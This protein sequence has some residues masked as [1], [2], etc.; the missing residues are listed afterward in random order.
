MP[1]DCIGARI[2]FSTGCSNS[3][4]VN[5]FARCTIV[6]EFVTFLASTLEGTWQV[7]TAVLTAS[8]VCVAFVD[9]NTLEHVA[10]LSEA[11]VAATL[12][13]ST[14]VLAFTVGTYVWILTALINI[15]TCNGRSHHSH[16]PGTLALEASLCV[17]ASTSS[18]G[19]WIS[20]L[21]LVD[22]F[23]HLHHHVVSESSVAGTSEAS[24]SVD[25]LATSTDAR[26]DCAFVYVNA[27]GVGFVHVKAGITLALETALH[28]CA[29][30]ILANLLE[31][32]LIDVCSVPVEPL[33]V[34]AQLFEGI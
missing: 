22:I 13:T 33:I 23:T 5:I 19:W 15:F 18:T 3:A 12:V 24:N 34:G 25:T 8:V 2:S 11:A 27:H 17:D 6:F 10:A 30:T 32:A 9:I 31:V 4:F 28:V 29:G 1:S 14:E 20:L 7:S 16:S 26:A 21:T